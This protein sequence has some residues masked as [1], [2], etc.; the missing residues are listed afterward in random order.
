MAHALSKGDSDLSAVA[1]GMFLDAEPGRSSEVGLC[2]CAKLQ[3]VQ[4]HTLDM[5]L[6][7]I[8]SACDKVCVKPCVN[9]CVSASLHVSVGVS[10]H[11]SVRH[12]MCQCVCVCRRVCHIQHMLH[13]ALTHNAEG[14]Y[15]GMQEQAHSPHSVSSPVRRGSALGPSPLSMKG[16][17]SHGHSNSMGSI[18]MGS[19]KSLNA[20]Q[21]FNQV[22]S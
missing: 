9:A 11:A 17:P 21:G 4:T 14:L 16:R 20:R 7:L 6:I 10:K 18:S 1:N 19:N 2:Q 15:A 3:H 22:Y 12:C 8:V 13:V 5:T